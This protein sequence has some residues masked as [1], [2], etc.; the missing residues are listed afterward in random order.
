EVQYIAYGTT[1]KRF[2]TSNTG[3]VKADVIEKQPVN[4]PLL[5]L[6]GR[7]PGLEII[8][9]NGIPGGGVTVRIQGRNNINPNLVGSD[10]LI[11]IDGVPYMS[12]NLTTFLG[13]ADNTSPILGRSGDNILTGGFGNP[14]SNINPMDIESIDVL[15]DADATA[16][17][18]SRA[19]NG[20][21]L[22]TTKRGKTGPMR[23][24]LNIQQ[25]WGNVGHKMDLLNNKQYMEMR[26]EAKAN[27]GA[28]VLMSD[29]DLRGLW[30][31]TQNTDWQKTLI[32]NTA[33]Y[34]NLTAG[35]SGGN[36]NLQYLISGTWARETSVFPGDFAN[37]RGSLHFNLSTAST[38]QRLKIQLGGSYMAN[39]NKLPGFD[40]TEIALTLPPVAP[41]PYNS[42]GTLNWA[43]DSLRGGISSWF[44]PFARQYNLFETKVD[45]L[46]AN[47][48][49]SYR[50]LPGLEF[51]STFGFTSTSS[52]QFT[53]AFNQSFKPEALP[54][55]IRNALFSFNDVQTWIVEPQ[56]NYQRMLGKGRLNFLIG[57][58]FQQQKSEGRGF[59]VSGQP[60]DQLLRNMAAGGAFYPSVPD[61][62]VYRYNGLFTRIG[63]IYK[64]RYLINATGRRDGSS[65]FG[66][67]NQLQNFGAIGLGWIISEETFFKKLVNVV[68][69]AKFKGSYGITG[70]DQ[71]GNYRFMNL[72]GLQTHGI[73]YQG[74]EGL[75]PEGLSNPNLE[76]ESTIKLQ[77]GV[78]LGFSNDHVLLTVNYIRNR[79]SNSLTEVDLP[80][81]AGFPTINANLEALVQNTSWEFSLSSKNIQKKHFNWTASANLTI[82]RNTLLEFPGLE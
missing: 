70:N 2:T 25:G 64:D 18:G 13:G 72:Y 19:A 65:R 82:P 63:Y 78:D 80:R 11:V 21:I 46:I 9:S 14:L 61:M 17:Y 54:G 71:L 29:Y 30:D 15:K 59:E 79:S 5:A 77:G 7:V 58:T 28:A 44:N 33:H 6:Q 48:A 45:N 23:V 4:N 40:F 74:Q 26:W 10:P 39:N 34:T 53:A 76:W 49:L 38:N 24:N 50:V 8:Q 47:G 51:K 68:S 37:T 42:D 43:P 3:T 16:I 57:S 52:N 75:R 32:G 41:S 36:Q 27:D 55:R 56:L 81:T 12:Q 73:P 31:T 1:N 62:S 22:I 35:V 69:F 20:A 67:N 60:S 66:R